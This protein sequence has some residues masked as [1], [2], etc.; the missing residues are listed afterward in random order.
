MS[1]LVTK[2]ACVSAGL[3]I[4]ALAAG[5]AI[6]A[7]PIAGSKPQP[8]KQSLSVKQKND[9]AA[10]MARR[11]KQKAAPKTMAEAEATMEVSGGVTIVEVPEEVYNYLT[12]TRDAHGKM[13]VSDTNATGHSHAAAVEAAN[14]N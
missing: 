13:R 2:I 10:A 3:V 5:S 6:A 14:E 8:A 4:A 7:K 11:G 1:H 12:A 9:M